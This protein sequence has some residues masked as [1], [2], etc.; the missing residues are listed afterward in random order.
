MKWLLFILKAYLSF[1]IRIIG[2]A[3][4]NEKHQWL[5]SDS[6]GINL[7]PTSST[8]NPDIFQVQLYVS[9]DSFNGNLTDPERALEKACGS[10]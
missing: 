6:Y 7:S 4:I 8:D 10:V 5:Y 2:G 1:L 3:V 9:T